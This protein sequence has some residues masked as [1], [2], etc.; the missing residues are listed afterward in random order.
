MT[1]EDVKKELGEHLANNAKVVPNMVYSDE[2][3]LDRLCKVITSIKGS[4]PS[5]HSIMTNVVQGFKP[6]WQELGEAQIKSKK[7]Q[8]YRQKVNFG[9]IPAEILNTYL[10]GDYYDEEK[11]LPNKTIS[12]YIL[13]EELKPKVIDDLNWLS[14]MAE[15]DDANADGQFGSSLSGFKTIVEDAVA[16]ATHPA[17]QIPVNALTANNI[18]DEV[19]DFETKLPEKAKMKV[20]AIMMSHSNA[21]RYIRRYVEQYGD[22]QFKKDEKKTF[23]GRDI[24][25]LPFLDDDKIVA[26]T[27]GNLV[28]LIDKIDN[29]PM[30]TDLQK[31]DY[32]LKI[33]MEFS[34]GYDFLINEMVFVANYADTTYGLGETAKNQLYYGIDG[35]TPA[36]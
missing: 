22:N 29:P 30:I 18:V 21:E 7:L 35:V 16:H 27:D 2:V 26:T 10:A 36:P 31:D 14:I 4:F 33:F 20:K 17:F 9:L 19:T 24:I 12:Q 34:V 13:E 6:E 23:F 15:R 1:I 5:F 11:D 8:T 3:V 28:K 25:A 32:K